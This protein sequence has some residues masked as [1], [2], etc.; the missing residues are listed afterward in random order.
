MCDSHPAWS[1]RLDLHAE[2][3]FNTVLILR[4]SQTQ[5][6]VSRVFASENCLRKWLPCISPWQKL[7]S[8]LWDPED[9]VV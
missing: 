8:T 1:T 2:T 9:P 3:A 4:P 5:A 6:L 7:E